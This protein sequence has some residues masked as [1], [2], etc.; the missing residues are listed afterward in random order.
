MN[1]KHFEPS[2]NK[3]SKICY[4]HFFLLHLWILIPTNTSRQQ[5]SVHDKYALA[6]QNGRRIKLISIL[7]WLFFWNI[8]SVIN[9][10]G[11]ELIGCWCFG[12]QKKSQSNRIQAKFI[13]FDKYKINENSSNHFDSVRVF[14][15]FFLFRFLFSRIWLKWHKSKRIKVQY[16]LKMSIDGI[17]CLSINLIRLW[18][19]LSMDNR[20]ET[21][22]R[23]FDIYEGKITSSHS[24]IIS[25]LLY[26]FLCVCVCAMFDELW[27]AIVQRFHFVGGVKLRPYDT[28]M[29]KSHD[30]RSIR[31]KLN[32]PFWHSIAHKNKL[33]KQSTKLKYNFLHNV[34]HIS[35]EMENMGQLSL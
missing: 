24:Y 20:H 4:S 16:Q 18:T 8:L 33:T 12:C 26:S 32:F 11:I 28:N 10:I 22:K 13:F 34:I 5:R 15:S 6:E 17:I 30:I 21:E 2:F 3:S 14:I 19:N 29:P 1:K 23:L 25:L 27:W 31:L 7:R 35:Q 9:N